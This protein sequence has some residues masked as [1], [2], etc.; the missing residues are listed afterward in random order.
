M[1]RLCVDA[2][3]VFAH[4]YAVAPMAFVFVTPSAG[5]VRCAPLAV[6]FVLVMWLQCIGLLS[7]CD[8]LMP[9][10]RPREGAHNLLE[11]QYGYSILRCRLKYGTV[12]GTAL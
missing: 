9:S 8:G 1:F 5:C 2:F 7:R 11:C 6:G 4:L 3:L 10:F 12:L